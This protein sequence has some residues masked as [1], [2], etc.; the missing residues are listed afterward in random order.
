MREVVDSKNPLPNFLAN[1]LNR[2]SLKEENSSIQQFKILASVTIGQAQWKILLFGQNTF[3][4]KS[5]NVLS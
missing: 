1:S 5:Q 4:P 2:N 3:S